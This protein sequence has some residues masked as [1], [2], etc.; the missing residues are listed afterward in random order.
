M[1]IRIIPKK[2]TRVYDDIEDLNAFPSLEMVNCASNGYGGFSDIEPGMQV[3]IDYAL[4]SLPFCPPPKAVEDSVRL[5]VARYMGF[6]QVQTAPSGF[7]TNILAFAAVASVAAEQGRSVIFLMDRDCHNSMFTGAFYNK[8]AKIHKFKH[9]DMADLENMLR[10][11]G[12]QNP[13]ALICVAVEG[14]YRYL[15]TIRVPITRLTST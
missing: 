12:E 11:Y 3:V 10:M 14:I 9:N 5:E 13:L 6:D 1:T 15:F 8:G 7:S 2:L 4:R